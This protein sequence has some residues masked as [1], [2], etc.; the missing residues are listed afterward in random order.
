MTK[1]A[2]EA[3]LAVRALLEAATE[4]VHARAALRGYALS[5][6]SED[7]VLANYIVRALN[8]LPPRP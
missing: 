6:R 2:I 1:P 8:A 3:P 4:D 7:R 5:V